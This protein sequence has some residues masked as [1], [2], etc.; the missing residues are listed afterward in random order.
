MEEKMIVT[1]TCDKCGTVLQYDNRSII[2]GCR[3][4]EDVHCPVC[5][6]IIDTVFTDLV[7]IARVIEKISNKVSTDK[8]ESDK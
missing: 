5:N 6:N 2:E 7:P 4:F 8:Q 3:D 1:K